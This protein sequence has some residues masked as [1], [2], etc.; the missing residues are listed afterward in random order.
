M[1]FQADCFKRFIVFLIALIVC[2]I[3]GCNKTYNQ[4]KK[5]TYIK[6]ANLHIVE[7]SFKHHDYILFRDHQSISRF[8]LHSPD[9]E[10]KKNDFFPF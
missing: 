7:F 3:C 6:N 4:N 1:K 8:V 10:C 5:T 2:L 9:C